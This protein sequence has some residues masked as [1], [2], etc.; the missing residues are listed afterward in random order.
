MLNYIQLMRL[1]K[2]IGIW[3][4]FWP[5]AWAVALATHG[6][7]LPWKLLGLLWLGA[8]LVRAAGCVI[9]DLADQQ[10]DAQVARTKTRPLASGA[11]SRRAAYAV[12]ALLLGLAFG[13]LFLLPHNALWLALLCLPLIAAYPFMKR[14]TWW[15]QLFLGITFNM[16]ALFGWLE[17]TGSLTMPAFWLYVAAI[18]WTL[19]YD[20]IYA[21]QD[22]EDDA[23]IGVKSTARHLGGFT[24]PFVALCYVHMLMVL[25]WIGISQSLG[26]PYMVGLAA[27]SLHA[28]WQ[29]WRVQKHGAAVAGQIFRSNGW[30]GALIFAAMAAKSL[31]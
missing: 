31:H 21:M 9:N 29:I 17:V 22:R 5:A 20:T 19:G 10:F 25:V 23:R 16:S 6:G 3:L 26:A 13:L 7:P 18:F 27:A 11:L 12:L 14:F 24:L 28:A 8:S 1:D 2:P 4:T 30:L 15:P